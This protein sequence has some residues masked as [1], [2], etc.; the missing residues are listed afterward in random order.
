MADVGELV[1][2][3]HADLVAA[4]A[5]EQRVEQ[6]DPLGRAEPGHVGVGRGGPAAGVDRVHLPDLDSGR[7]GQLEHVG[8]RLA[9]RER[10]EVVEQRIEHDRR[11]R[12]QDRAE[13]HRARR[14]PA[15]TTGADSACVTPPP[16][17]PP[18]PA[19]SRLDRRALEQ[20]AA[21]TRA[22]TA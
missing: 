20:V 16:P 1:R 11:E 17:R 4:V 10:R 19:G 7:A 14:A 3:H 21:P 18:P 22:T 13:Q 9:L 5:V 6:D 15:A 12:R 2:D 8:P